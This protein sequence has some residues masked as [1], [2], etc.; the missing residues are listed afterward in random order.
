[1]ETVSI[2]C[3]TIFSL[4]MVEMATPKGIMNMLD[5]IQANMIGA[6]LTIAKNPC[7]GIDAYMCRRG[8]AA[9]AIAKKQGVWSS[10]WL[11]RAKA[12]QAHLQRHPESPA[13]MVMSWHNRKWL[14]ERRAS[15]L[16]VRKPRA[17]SLSMF[18]SW[19]GTRSRAGRPCIRFEEG[20]EN[21]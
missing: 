21:F 5:G 1:M 3:C 9:R 20:C 19:T 2:D 7:E 18:A 16:A 15:L 10:S 6:L 8:R 13:G 12:R 14:Q 4:Q 11:Q 17:T